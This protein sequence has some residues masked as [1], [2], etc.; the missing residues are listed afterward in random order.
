MKTVKAIHSTL[1][2]KFEWFENVEKEDNEEINKFLYQY[3]HEGKKIF[4]WD[5]CEYQILQILNFKK[6]DFCI[7]LF[8]FIKEPTK[9]NYKN[10]ISERY[11]AISENIVTALSGETSLSTPNEI[12]MSFF[13]SLIYCPID[14]QILLLKSLIS[15][16]EDEDLCWDEIDGKHTLIPLALILANDYTSKGMTPELKGIVNDLL[17]KYPPNTLYSNVYKNLFSNDSEVVNSLFNQLCQ[18]HLEKSID[19]PKNFPEF[20]FP[21]HQ[22]FPEEIL[23]LLNL[24]AQNGLS[25]SMIKHPLIDPFLPFINED[26]LHS[27]IMTNKQLCLR[28]II[29]T[30]FNY[31]PIVSTVD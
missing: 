7:P 26:V 27:D 18:Y 28:E 30:E 8:N 2:K 6:L 24:R 10:L 13:T 21:V 1:K 20:E 5:D 14:E 22:A 23:V 29:F 4:V 25:N 12:A 16:E 3:M 11:Y 9:E 31:T 19:N 17:N 15:T